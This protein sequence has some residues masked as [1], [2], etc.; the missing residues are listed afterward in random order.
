MPFLAGEGMAMDWIADYVKFPKIVVA[1]NSPRMLHEI[2]SYVATAVPEHSE[3]DTERAVIYLPNYYPKDFKNKPTLKTNKY[4]GNEKY[5]IDIGCFG[6]IR[7]LKNHLTQAIAA[8]KYANEHGKQLRFHIN[9]GRI[10]GKAEPV[11]NNLIG[12][13]QQLG[14]HNHQLIAHEWVPREQFLELCAQ[15]DVGLQCNFSE[16]FNIVTA[17]LVSQGVPIVGSSEIPWGSKIFTAIP[18]DSESIAHAI[19][20]AAHHPKLN[21]YLN[22]RGLTKYCKQTKKIWAKYF[23]E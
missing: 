20:R 4:R 6:A 10:E 16:T 18:T 3:Q 23:K 13:F 15:M 8:L 7:P 21:V 2:K 9:S 22:R 17:D 5:W 14:E 12:M 1:A 11:L 19:A